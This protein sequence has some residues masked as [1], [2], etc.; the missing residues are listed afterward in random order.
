M[1]LVKTREGFLFDG[2]SDKSWQGG[3]MYKAFVF[4]C[5]YLKP[6]I[7]PVKLPLNGCEKNKYAVYCD[8]GYLF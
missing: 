1:T 8:P 7:A 3:M 5:E 6:C 4:D 2:H